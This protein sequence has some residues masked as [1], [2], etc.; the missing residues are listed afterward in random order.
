[1][2]LYDFKSHVYFSFPVVHYNLFCHQVELFG[3]YVYSFM[4]LFIFFLMIYRKV[5]NFLKNF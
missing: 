1:M 5:L 2:Q 3:K 4:I